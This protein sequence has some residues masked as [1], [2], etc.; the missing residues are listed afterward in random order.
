MNNIVIDIFKIPGVFY[1][2]RKKPIKFVFYN[3][4]SE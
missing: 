3:K 4:L 1:Y 2:T